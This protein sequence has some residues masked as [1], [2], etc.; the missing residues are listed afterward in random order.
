MPSHSA[1]L[2]RQGN[3]STPQ[4]HPHPPRIYSGVV[5]LVLVRKTLYA[6]LEKIRRRDEG[7]GRMMGAD[8][9]AMPGQKHDLSLPF[10]LLKR[11]AFLKM[12]GEA[13]LL[14]A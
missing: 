13:F 1:A 9:L 12:L 7:Q 2:Q 5:T 14:D 8:G 3:I 6:T 4:Q 10:P 11:V